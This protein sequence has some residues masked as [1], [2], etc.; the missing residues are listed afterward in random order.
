[1][2][3]KIIFIVFLGLLFSS[4]P[5]TPVDEI[6]LAIDDIVTPTA[7]LKRIS[8]SIRP[9]GSA[10]VVIGEL[11]FF[12]HSFNNLTVNCISLNMSGGKI[13]CARGK[14]VL[15]NTTADFGFM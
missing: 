2:G 5:A 6:A 10:N 9:D 3:W 13:Q 8:A 15:G 12:G 11:K 4:F 1:M 14:I 7:S